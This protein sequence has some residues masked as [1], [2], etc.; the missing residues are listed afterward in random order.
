VTRE[1][2]IGGSLGGYRVDA[3]AGR[4][5][6]GVVYRAWDPD[7]ERT[8][9]LKVISPELAE[10]AEFRSRFKRESQ[11]AA[12]IRHP[13]VITIYRAGDDDGLLYIAMEFIDG[14]DLRDTLKRHGRMDPRWAAWIVGETASALDAAHGRGLVHRDIK[15]ANIL[16]AQEG[17]RH[18]V[19]LTDFGL[20]KRLD[21]V[22]GETKTGMFLGTTDYVAPEQVMG[23]PLDARA[24][25]YALGCVLYHLVTGEV[26]YPRQQDMAKVLAHMSE[27][28]PSASA[29]QPGVP[30][31]LDEV[32]KRAMAK[33]P[34][35]RFPSAG[36]LA[37]AAQAAAA[38]HAMPQQGEQSV[39]AGDAAPVS[40]PTVQ[41]GPREAAAVLQGTV[42][43]SPGGPS[44][45][46]AQPGRPAAFGATRLETATPPPPP[47]PPVQ[48]PPPDPSQRQGGALPPPPPQRPGPPYSL[49]PKYPGGG[50]KSRTP[51]IV[52]GIAAALVALAV[53]LALVL[54]GGGSKHDNSSDSSSDTS[55]TTDT[56]D[57][58]TDTTASITASDAE[59]AVSDF[60]DASD[61]DQCNYVT[62]AEAKAIAKGSNTSTCEEAFSG[63][64]AATYTIDNTVDN[65]DGTYTVSTTE[66]DSNG[67]DTNWDYTV[68]LNSDGGASIDDYQ[69]Q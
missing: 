8:V 63:V 32:I 57:T 59:T 43:D 36:D 38:G 19:Y 25:V 21:S 34:N 64:P 40:G 42:F 30:P 50:G 4:G 3:V 22:K 26:P 58:T 14:S 65:G 5:G 18:H 37:R 61:G 23:A 55:V 2:Q 53:V 45:P 54:S 39:A 67:T 48:P 46:L 33:D 44:Q 24:D 12:S 20:T 41:P 49:P 56:T 52:G 62:E 16:I 29:H 68:V 13:N 11:T 17:D 35:A 28:P 51:L 27:P 31:A 69:K 60:L 66:T 15:P 6:M 1:L 9:A 10:N 7:L 47:P